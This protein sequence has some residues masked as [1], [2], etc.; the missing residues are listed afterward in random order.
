MKIK[1]EPKLVFINIE[2]TEEHIAPI[3]GFCYIAAFLKEKLHYGNI[4]QVNLVYA[5]EGLEGGILH[6]NPDIVGFRTITAHIYLI[7]KLSKC[8]KEK[9]GIPVIYGGPHITALPND[10]PPYV[11]LA[12]IGEGEQTMLELM[13]LFLKKSRF[14]TKDLVNVK[15][16]SFWNKEGVYFTGH[17]EL[18]RNLDD[19]PMPDYSICD[20]R[21]F[22]PK[23]RWLWLDSPVR[24]IP[25]MAS[26]G[27]AYR[28]FFC[29]PSHFEGF[30]RRQSIDKTFHDLSLIRKRYNVE[31]IAFY[32]PIFA[33]NANDLPPIVVPLLKREPDII[34]SR[35]RVICS[36]KS[37]VV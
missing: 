10:L 33:S 2:N 14:L 24:G 13:R 16:I 29:Q 17:R 30:L 9:H 28:C 31:L 34:L 11:D 36:L 20:D 19:L 25:Y 18:I 4:K 6:E 35:E 32:D 5:E 1:K 27:C 37:C 15:G 3:L 21:C 23:E 8:L 7:N 12:V 22:T 26:R